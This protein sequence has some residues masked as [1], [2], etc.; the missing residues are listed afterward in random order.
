MRFGEWK[1]SGA[2]AVGWILILAFQAKGE[3]PLPIKAKIHSLEF[4]SDH[5][6]IC[7]NTSNLF[8]G[9]RRYPDVE[10]VAEPRVNAPITHSVKEKVRILLTLEIKGLAE[11]TPFLLTGTSAEPGLCFSQQGKVTGPL[12][13]KAAAATGATLVQRLNGFSGLPILLDGTSHWNKEEEMVLE[14]ESTKPLGES[15]RKIHRSITWTLKVHPREK[16]EKN[17]KLGATGPHVVYTTLGTPRGT[18]KAMG[19][20]TDIRME[21]T[22]RQVSSAI[23]HIRHQ[24][25]NPSPL[26]I[27]HTL[28]VNNRAYRPTRDFL[29]SHAWYVPESPSMFPPGASCISIATFCGLVCQMTGMDGDIDVVKIYAHPSK[30][31]TALIGPGLGEKPVTRGGLQLLL[32]DGENTND[33]QPGGSGGVN[34]Y[35]AAL[36]VTHGGKTY[37]FPG[38]TNQV[39]RSPNP[40]LNVFRTLAW[41]SW[42]GGGWVVVDVVYTYTSGRRY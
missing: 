39:H 6:L 4:T 26:R 17:I 29:H 42:N 16:E 30:P 37:Y 36:R 10:W 21:R 32:V 3:T 22:I 33:G 25:K 15:L 27:A 18:E 41:C 5:N 11:G 24:G 35:E 14:L 20:V 9:G 38:G 28:M 19:V 31:R 7:K 34:Y 23:R 13:F 12:P 2:L 1:R 40:V 8:K